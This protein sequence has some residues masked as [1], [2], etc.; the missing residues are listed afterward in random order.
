VKYNTNIV[1]S[2][3]I[4]NKKIELVFPR[5]KREMD[6]YLPKVKGE[7]FFQIFSTDVDTIAEWFS[8]YEIDSME[9]K[10]DNIIDSSETT[11]LLVGSKGDNGLRV[12]LKPKPKMSSDSNQ[13]LPE[14]QLDSRLGREEGRWK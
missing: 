6:V 10:I 4:N 14:I 9:L 12:V 3:K 8:G 1:T 7:E 13:T 2:T 11:K 5:P